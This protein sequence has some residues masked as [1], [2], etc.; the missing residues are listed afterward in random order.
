MTNKTINGVTVEQS[1][2]TTPKTQKVSYVTLNNSQYVNST[3][4]KSDLRVALVKIDTN[5]TQSMA[6]KFFTITTE[7]SLANDTKKD[8]RAILTDIANRKAIATTLNAMV[9]SKDEALAK[10]KQ[11]VYDLFI[12]RGITDM[13]KKEMIRE[14]KKM[15]AELGLNVTYIDKL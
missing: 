11:R 7:K 3:D 4:G 15:C 8:N 1:I 13:G 6:N 12:K 5:F 10:K 14:A 2:K 9:N